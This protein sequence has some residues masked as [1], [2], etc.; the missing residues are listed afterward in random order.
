MKISEKYN[1]KK[2]DSLE[3]L[4]VELDKDNWFFINPFYINNSNDS[5]CIK[6]KPYLNSFFQDFL[7][8]LQDGAEDIAR[9]LFSHLKEINNIRLGMS[10]G[11]PAGRGVGPLNTEMIF[12]AVKETDVFNNGVISEIGDMMVFV[13]YLDIDKMSDMC[14]NIIKYELIQ[15]TIDQCKKYNIETKEF[16]VDYWDVSGTTWKIGKFNLPYD[17]K[18]DYLLF[19]PNSLVK[20]E[21]RYSFGEFLQKFILLFYQNKLKNENHPK[22]RHIEY[23]NKNSKD[24]ITKQEVLKI[25]KEDNIVDKK[26][27]ADFASDNKNEY[28]KYKDSCLEKFK[29]GF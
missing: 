29:G 9:E 7:V 11:D 1:I 23:K 4:D 15:F 21:F 26:F 13:K 10:Q 19:V 6:S 18:N 25:L 27:A 8:Q 17:K 3:F 22:V 12:T 16:D 2:P 14:A 5:F 20:N 28:K 24:V